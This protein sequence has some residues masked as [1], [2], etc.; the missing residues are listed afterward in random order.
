MAPAMEIHLK[1]ISTE[2]IFWHFCKAGKNQEPWPWLRWRRHIRSKPE[3]NESSIASQW[4][5]IGRIRSLQEY[6]NIDLYR[7]G[8]S[9]RNGP[10]RVHIKSGQLRIPGNKWILI[11]QHFRDLYAFRKRFSG[12][13]AGTCL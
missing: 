8:V 6:R 5:Y 3:Q 2:K 7:V 9:F 11:M 4:N 1:L 12:M 10:A 13:Q